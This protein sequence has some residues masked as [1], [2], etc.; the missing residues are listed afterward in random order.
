MVE[1]EQKKPVS[2]WNASMNYGT[3]L[4]VYYAAKFCLFPLGL[5]SPFASLL[6]VVLTIL[7]PVLAYKLTKR[8]R[9]TAMP[10]GRMT[11]SQAWSFTLQLF[12]FASILVAV[13][14]FIYFAFID[15]GALLQ[16]S[17]DS[18]TQMAAAMQEGATDAAAWQMQLDS[19]KQ[20][21]DMVAAMSPIELTLQLL[22]NNLFWGC[23]FGLPIAAINAA[24][25]V[26]SSQPDNN[27][28]N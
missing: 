10:E 7:V 1:E 16:A 15:H 8:F 19:M 28:E 26:G 23:I 14:H 22:V 6:F 18:L 9:L 12:M 24:K 17:Q 5:K 27:V 13:I 20:T 25:S 11:L 4:G 2:L 3:V 21:I